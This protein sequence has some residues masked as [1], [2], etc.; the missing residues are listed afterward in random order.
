MNNVRLALVS[1]LSLMTASCAVRPEDQAAW[2]GAPV[3]ALDKHP[4]FLTMPVVKTVAADGT[5]IRNYVNGRNFSACS[6]GGSAF[7]G[8]INFASYNAF[9]TCMSNFAACNNI[10]YIKNNKVEAYTPI[11]S[12][13]ARCYTD[14]RTQPGFRG[15]TNFR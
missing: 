12:G 2:L 3:S 8:T 6:G 1:L 14:E 15:A 9:S 13:G 10:F 5:E 4:V 7:S 11:G